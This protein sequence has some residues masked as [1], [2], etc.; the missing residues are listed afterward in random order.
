MMQKI[1]VSAWALALGMCAATS[2]GQ[3]ITTIAGTDWVFPRQDLP[4]VNAPLGALNGV[5][6][7]RN[8]NVF[9][10]DPSNRMVMRISLDGTLHV[11]AGNGGNITYSGD[12][13]PATNAGLDQLMGV[14]ADNAGNVYL[15]DGNRIR[16]V[17]ADGTITTFAGSGA[18]G[19]SGDGGPARDAA[20]YGPS[21]VAVDA[22][23]NVY[24]SDRGNKRVRQM[25]LDGT[26]RTV[27]GTGEEGFS[28]DGGSATNAALRQP[29]AVAVDRHG[30]LYISDGGNFRVRMM[31]TDGTITTIAGNGKFGAPS[32]GRARSE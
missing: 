28:G 18:H 22:A 21:G 14:A 31:M 5:A 9:V 23:G 12:G 32:G 27:A 25:T 15:V 17:A 4:A 24:I 6:V 2:F 16:K 3:V 7:D 1:T 26:I 19:S 29:L 20:L 11:I 13:G 30:N 10:T 8:G